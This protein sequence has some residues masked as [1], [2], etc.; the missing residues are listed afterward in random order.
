MTDV[1]QL[2]IFIC[3]VDASLTVTKEFVEMVPMTNT[4]S[5]NNVF[6]SLVEA[7]DTLGADTMD[8]L[9]AWQQMAHRP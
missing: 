2:G 3:C 6:S 1:A 4:T 8:T 7:L 5:A 9:S